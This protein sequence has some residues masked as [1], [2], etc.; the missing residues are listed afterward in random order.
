MRQKSLAGNQVYDFKNEYPSK[1]IQKFYIFSKKLSTFIKKIRQPNK[2][3]R[4]E[5]LL[6]IEL[7]K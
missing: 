4:D 7:S 1:K 2:M 5:I 6:Q 3:Q